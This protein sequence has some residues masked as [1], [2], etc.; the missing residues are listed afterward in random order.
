MG[1]KYVDQILEI[2][3]KVI[4]KL[5]KQQVSRSEMQFGFMSRCGMANTGSFLGP[6]QVNILQKKDIMPY[7]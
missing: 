5:I 7:I 2:V 4:L 6:L 3:E 1:L